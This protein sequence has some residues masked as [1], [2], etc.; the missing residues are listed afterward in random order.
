MLTTTQDIYYLVAAITLP[1]VGTLLCVALVRV[2]A[3]LKKADEIMTTVQEGVEIVEEGVRE[4]GERVQTLTNYGSLI[5][6]IAKSAMTAYK[7]K[8]VGACLDDDED[9]EAEEAPR[10]RR[11]RLR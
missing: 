4:V 1:V 6:G 3:I 9:E 7:R 11:R 5:A 10:K 2:I 8:S